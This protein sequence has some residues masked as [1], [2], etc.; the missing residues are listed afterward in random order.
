YFYRFISGN[1]ISEIGRTKTLATNTDNVHLGVFSCANFTATNEFLA[2]GR[3]ADI[4]I[5]NPYDA[6]I[7]LGDYIY[8][9]GKGGYSSAE[10]ASKTRGFSPDKE[11]ISLDDYRQ[12]YAQYQSD[13]SLREM[14]A[15]APLIAIWDDHETAND[16][17]ETG[18]ENHQ[19]DTEGSWTTRR[20]VALKAYYEWMPIREPQLRDGTDQGSSST[21]LTKGYRSFDFADV[22]SLH[23]LETRLLAR[24]Q[25]LAYPTAAT[26]Q[27]RIG[28]ILTSP[29]ETAAYAT[30]YKVAA[31][32]STADASRFGAAIASFVTNEL[33]AKVVNEVYFGNREMLG[34]EQLTWLKNELTTST[35]S[36]QV[37]GSGTLMMNM[38]IP[39][40]L[41]LNAGDPKVLAKYAA[42]LQ[43]LAAGQALT[44]E[45]QALFSEA[46]KIPYNLDAWDGYG[47]EREEIIKAALQLGKKL[48]NLAGDT[49]NAWAGILDAMSNADIAQQAFPSSNFLVG[50][51]NRS[52][53]KEIITSGEQAN[54]GFRFNGTPDGIGVIDNGT[55]LRV[56]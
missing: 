32:T 25:Q 33:V 22:L 35:A 45:E 4:N 24:D 26:V 12:R 48:V 54:N 47:A 16:S 6:F 55:T 43:K 41:L 18:A 5:S 7:H 27:A 2:Y 17:Y 42:P 9:Y 8:E 37:L 40:E 11:V 10:D 13:A 23:I 14:R 38:A 39:A 50:T 21:P 56:L 46:G 20:D 29:T 31:P 44:A 19:P 34:S 52:A 3:A 15:S 28:Q 1:S 30:K 36:W 51:E 49:H 53:F